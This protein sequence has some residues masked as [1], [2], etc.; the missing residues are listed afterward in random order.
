M[1]T[2][3]IEGR[4]TKDA[5][6][7]FTKNGNPV[8]KFRIAHN[9]W[10]KAKQEEETSFFNVVVYKDL[11]LTKGTLVMIEGT[12]DAYNYTNGDNKSITYTYIMGYRITPFNPIKLDKGFGNTEK[13]KSVFQDDSIPF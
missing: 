10:N 3:F 6:R 9:K 1:N 4:L 12:L 13:A 5:D 2:I 7:S 8:T 11:N